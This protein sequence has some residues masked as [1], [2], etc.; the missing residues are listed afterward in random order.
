MERFEA[1]RHLKP[2]L[3]NGEAL[4][5]G[6]TGIDVTVLDDLQKRGF[7][8]FLNDLYAPDPLDKFLVSKITN[9]GK[10]WMSR[11][12]TIQQAVVAELDH[13]EHVKSL[14]T[15]ELIRWIAGW[16]EGTVP[17][18]QGEHE[19]QSRRAKGTELRG[20]IAIGISILS[21]LVAFFALLRKK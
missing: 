14:K 9:Q 19:L 11:R 2:L 5:F 1:L 4:T 6:E 3:E 13:S 15:P 7:I 10:S 20:W 21:L 16:G 12:V 17:R 18:M 8:E